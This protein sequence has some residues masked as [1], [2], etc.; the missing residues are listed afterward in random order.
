MSEY[1]SCKDSGDNR[2]FQVS[3]ESGYTQRFEVSAVKRMSINLDIF[4]CKKKLLKSIL[5]PLMLI[6]GR[7]NLMKI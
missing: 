1:L 5:N 2:K 4:F 6:V 3:V 7:P